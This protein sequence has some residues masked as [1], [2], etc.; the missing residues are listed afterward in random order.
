MSLRGFSLL[1]LE[2]EEELKA[3]LE[4]LWM[5]KDPEGSPKFTQKQIAKAL[6]FGGIEV[7]PDGTLNPYADLD[8][9]RVYYYRYKFNLPIH[10]LQ[11]WDLEFERMFS[12]VRTCRICRSF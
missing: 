4:A 1:T 12:P 7:L 6:G 9:H 10:I 8:P 11:E 3:Q 5:L 2:Q